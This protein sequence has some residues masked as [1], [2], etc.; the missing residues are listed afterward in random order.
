MG[1]VGA[2]WRLRGRWASELETVGRAEWVSRERV[3][4]TDLPK[5]ETPTAPKQ[6]II[7]NLP[8][9][10]Y[11]TLRRLTK[12]VPRAIAHLGEQRRQQA[13]LAESEAERLD[14]IRNP[15]KYRGK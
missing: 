12:Q 10:F 15:A 3:C 2:Y 8:K 5:P 13:L 9:H 1:R 14:R 7:V 6:A 4:E 11:L